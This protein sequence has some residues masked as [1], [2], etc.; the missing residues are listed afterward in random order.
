MD[1]EKFTNYQL[2]IHPDFVSYQLKEDEIKVF[3]SADYG[4]DSKSGNKTIGKEI[5]K[6]INSFHIK[7]DRECFYAQRVKD[8]AIKNLS[9]NKRVGNAIKIGI[10]SNYVHQMMLYQIRTFLFYKMHPELLRIENEN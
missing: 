9:Q 1:H 2:S 10:A 8:S 3:L 5:V 7:K 4:V 6:T